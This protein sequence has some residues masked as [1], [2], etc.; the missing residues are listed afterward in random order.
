MGLQTILAA[1]G[2]GGKNIPKNSLVEA[3]PRKSAVPVKKPTATPARKSEIVEATKTT[4]AAIAAALRTKG[5]VRIKE[6]FLVGNH[7][8]RGSLTAS[9]GVEGNHLAAIAVIDLGGSKCVLLVAES[10]LAKKDHIEIR[11]K[12]LKKNL[13]LIDERISDTSLISEINNAVN[14]SI[15]EKTASDARPIADEIVHAAIDDGATDIHICNRYEYKTGMV[16]QRVNGKIHQYRR[17]SSTVC[18]NIAGILYLIS[19]ASSRTPNNFALNA[20]QINCV[21]AVFYK[22]EAY[23]LRYQFVLAADGWDVIIRIL[24]VSDTKKKTFVELGY[25]DSQVKS[26]ELAVKKRM[27]LVAILGPT[28]SGKSTTLKTMME[29]DPHRQAK[30]RYSIEDPPEYKIFGVSQIASKDFASTLRDILRADPDDVMVGETRDEATASVVANGVT[31]GHKIYTT[32]H[33]GSA[34]GAYT[35]LSRLSLDRFILA[36]RQFVAAFVFQRLMPVLCGNCRLKAV[37]T[38]VLSHEQ[39]TYLES[40]FDLNLDDIYVVNEEGCQYC[41]AGIAKATVVAEVIVPDSALRD[42][43]IRQDDNG[44][45]MYWRSTRRTR[46]DDPD[47]TGKTAFEHALY[48][49]SKGLIDPRDVENEF[50]SFETYEVVRV[51]ADRV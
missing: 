30:K 7:V 10:L 40:K 1:F 39:T 43:I 42:F 9:F 48:K 25:A 44:A 47:M 38:N 28:G 13:E 41:R 31:T 3:S 2:I 50:E 5:R 26:I 46:F 45:E 18:N 32:L 11:E 12:I 19:E 15:D 49:V 4:P 33:T 14:G 20:T 29:F 17:Y 24:H 21:I 6:D 36:D 34:I 8:I 27:G 37:K 16:L 23:K 51:S 35:R 22:N